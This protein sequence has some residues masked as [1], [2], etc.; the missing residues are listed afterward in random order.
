MSVEYASTGLGINKNDLQ[1]HFAKL[2]T[3][4]CM[5]S[6]RSSSDKLAASLGKRQVEE[7]ERQSVRQRKCVLG[8]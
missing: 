8:P 7:L 6:R 2:I 1:N 3:L 5:E 4:Q